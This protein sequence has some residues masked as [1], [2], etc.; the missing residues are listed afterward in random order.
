M[1]DGHWCT[2]SAANVKLFG[3]IIPEMN[4]QKKYNLTVCEFYW[5]KNLTK[6]IRVLLAVHYEQGCVLPSW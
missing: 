1:L 2:S 6:I 3:Q 4:T 5:E